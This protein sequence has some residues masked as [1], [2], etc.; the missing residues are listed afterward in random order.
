MYKSGPCKKN[1]AGADQRIKELNTAQG[2]PIL[3]T[4]APISEKATVW[5]FA[6]SF[7]GNELKISFQG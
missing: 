6:L 5:K 1:A 3:H 4:E 2:I 7:S